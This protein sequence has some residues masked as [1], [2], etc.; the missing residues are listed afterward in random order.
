MT[1]KISKDKK[2]EVTQ[3]TEFYYLLAKKQRCYLLCCKNPGESQIVIGRYG[4]EV[5]A[6]FMFEQIWDAIKF[7]KRQFIVGVD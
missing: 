7:K 6:R 3:E 5:Q 4:D 1:L 2:V